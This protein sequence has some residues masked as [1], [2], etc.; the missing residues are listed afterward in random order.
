MENFFSHIGTKLVQCY[1]K[2]ISL[3]R[4]DIKTQT[5]SE[6]DNAVS[7]QITSSVMDAMPRPGSKFMAISATLTSSHLTP[8]N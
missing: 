3:K 7:H 6:H 5:D 1:L 4:L 8:T 2:T